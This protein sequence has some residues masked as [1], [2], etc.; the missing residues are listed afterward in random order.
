MRAMM[1]TLLLG[2]L[3][4]GSMAAYGQRFEEIRDLNPW[5]EG[6]NRAG[7]RSDANTTFSYAEVWG[8]L[9]R[10]AMSDHSC[11]PESY[12]AGVKT[13]SIRH[14]GKISYMGRFAYDYLDGQEM[15]GSM[16]LRPGYWPVDIYEYTPGRKVREHYAF[17]GGL[18][19]DLGSEWRGGLWVDFTA[20]NYAKR[21]DLRHKNTALDLEAAP[22]V[23][24]HRG[25][26]SVGLA[27]L[28]EKHSE[29]VEAEEIGST[30][31]S[32]LAF[33]DKGLYYGVEALWTSN[34]LH[35]N[36]SGISAFPIQK[37]LHG[38]SLQLQYGSM[39]IG[40][41]ELFAE[42]EYHHTKGDS[43]EKGTTWHLFE[44]DELTGRLRWQRVTAG[45]SL[46]R[47]RG[48]ITWEQLF[49]RETILSTETAGG[50]TTS[51]IYGSV[52]IFESRQ[53]RSDLS[54]TWQRAGD[55]IEVGAE[56]LLQRKQSSLLYPLLRSQSMRQW[57]VRTEGRWGLGGVDLSAGLFGSWG[58]QVT[59]ESCEGELLPESPYPTQQLTYLNWQNEFLTATRL[60]ALAG[61]RVTLYRELYIDLTARYEHGFRLQYLPQPNRVE[62]ILSLGYRW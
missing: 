6:F 47:L 5:N 2:L 39:L 56:Y 43:G 51:T 37:Q 1:K 30:P 21:K 29:R 11:S 38:A 13:E 25:I 60:G 45:G 15:S 26:W 61:V 52:P 9:E 41:G 50:I 31:D 12:T 18:S 19:A 8:G 32:Y 34:E 22:S 7:L 46:H 44:G 54:Y 16:M 24:W 35:L 59:H 14:F 62:A 55:R 20:A 49:N 33:F 58:R 48:E 42:A 10:G 28:Y 40:P 17:A 3:L 57:R 36:E 27:Y 53:L 23:Q 4:S